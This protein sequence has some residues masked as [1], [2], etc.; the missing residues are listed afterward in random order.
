M[1]KT[2]FNNILRDYCAM[3]MYCP[4]TGEILDYRRAVILKKGNKE[5]VVSKNGL[6]KLINDCKKTN[7]IAMNSI[8]WESLVQTPET[9][10]LDEKG[11]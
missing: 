8:D 9:Y 2:L 5:K 4:V 11:K 7:I 6:K 3:A 1:E 10:F